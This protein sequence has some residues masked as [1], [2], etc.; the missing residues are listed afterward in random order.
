MFF[1]VVIRQIVFHP[2]EL[3]RFSTVAC[4]IR[5]TRLLHVIVETDLSQGLQVVCC[6]PCLAIVW[7]DG[8]DL[9]LLF[10]AGAFPL[11]GVFLTSSSARVQNFLSSSKEVLNAFALR[12]HSAIIRRRSRKFVVFH[13][14]KTLHE[15][16]CQNLNT[17]SVLHV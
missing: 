17:D 8:V 9:F 10:I 1:N 4:A 13:V 2:A 16:P 7:S 5:P 14:S 6:L 15:K 12:Q 3:H 11:T